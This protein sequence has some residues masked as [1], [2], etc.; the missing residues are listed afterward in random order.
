VVAREH[1]AMMRRLRRGYRRKL[2]HE[3]LVFNDEYRKEI[4]RLR[5]VLRQRFGET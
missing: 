1:L 3:V 2:R 5:E 4:E